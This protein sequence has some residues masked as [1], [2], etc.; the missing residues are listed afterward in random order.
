MALVGPV[1]GTLSNVGISGSVIIADEPHSRFP[2]MP[3]T[4]T[5]VFASGSIGK[6]G[7]TG[8]SASAFGGDVVISGSLSVG[9]GSAGIQALNVYGNADGKFVAL[10]DNDQSSNGHVLRLKTDGNGSGSRLLEMTDGDDDTIFRARADGR[11]GFGPD[12]VSSMGAGT[13]VVGIDGGHTADIAISKR[14]QH[15]GDSDTYMDFPAVDKIQ[16]VAGGVDMVN[17]TEDGTNSQI[18]ILSGGAPESQDPAVYGD[19]NFFI[20]GTVGSRGTATKGTSVFGG[21]AVISGALYLDEIT[22]PGTQPDGTVA[23]YGKDDSGVT[24]LYFKNESGETEI[25]S[26]GSG[27]SWDG[28][29]ANGIATFKD[30]DEATVEAN[31]TFDG[32]N[33]LIA[34]AGKLQFRNANT[35]INSSLDG[36]LDVRASSALILSGNNTTVV[37]DLPDWASAMPVAGV[38]GGFSLKQLGTGTSLT[39]GAVYYLSGSGVWTAARASHIE[40]GSMNFMTVA[41][42][43]TNELDMFVNGPVVVATGQIDGPSPTLSGSAVYL[44]KNTA[45]SMTFTAP[46]G[47]GESVKILGHCIGIDGPSLLIWFNPESGWIELS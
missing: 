14:L 1:S 20:S 46:T 6:R 42:G 47:S 15:L 4:D 39:E 25:G 18:L 9:T 28:S 40:S 17:M 13:F 34:S 11:F 45:G 8:G 35:F 22:A 36:F 30:A 10:I 43:T 38:G 37:Q 41:G 26:G 31:F 2:G 16:L 7:S 5:T 3:G 44:S 23:I 32:T 24:K 33:S 27:I 12:G 21:D 19:T 29:T